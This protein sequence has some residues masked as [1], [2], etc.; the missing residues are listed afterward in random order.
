MVVLLATGGYDNTIRFWDASSGMCYR[1]LQHP[2]RQVN[3]LQIRPDKQ[4]IA[5]GGNPQIR[6]YDVNSKSADPVVTYDGHAGNVTCIGFQRDGRWMWSGSDDG[7]IKI[8]DLRAPTFQRDYESR[9]G[10]NSVALHPNQG[11]LVSGDQFGTVRVW[12]LTANKCSN[13][14]IPEGDAPISSVTVAADASLCVATNYNGN[15]Y[16]WSP[17]SSEEFV[18]VKK[19]AAHKAYVTAARLS[20][21][22][23]FLATASSDRTVKLWNTR[24][25]SLAATLAGHSKWVWDCVFSADST[26]LV[27]ASSDSHAKLWE[28]GMAEVV[29]TYTGH[30]KAITAVAL[31]DAAPVAPVS[32]PLGAPGAAA[33]AAAGGSG[34]GGAAAGG[35][36]TA[37]AGGGG[38][39]GGGAVAT[40]AGGASRAAVGDTHHH[41]D[42]GGGVADR[43][44]VPAGVAAD[45]T[46]AVTDVAV[47]RGKA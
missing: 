19:L 14:L 7:S 27:T 4:Y 1:T 22:V 35:G 24:D 41:P 16:F 39:G 43:A 2:D 20:P 30:S 11:E 32:G 47:R 29:R 25:F 44:A 12:D 9:A 34:T 42:A 17:R 5:A 18:P 28:V 8:W 15:A 13:E 46:G 36:G 38:G 45:G 21:D 33:G 31:N 3:C 6:I 26:Y 37:A 10:V 23:R 40:G